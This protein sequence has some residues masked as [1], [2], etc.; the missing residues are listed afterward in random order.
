LPSW[1]SSR[2]RISLYSWRTSWL[3]E[4]WRSEFCCVS[5]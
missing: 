4:I 5:E 2:L 1:F 3:A